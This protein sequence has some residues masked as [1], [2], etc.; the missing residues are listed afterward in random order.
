MAKLFQ[1]R[2]PVEI[3]PGAIIDLLQLVLSNPESNARH[4]A[5]KSR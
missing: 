5:S 4:V 3:A 1:P 2:D